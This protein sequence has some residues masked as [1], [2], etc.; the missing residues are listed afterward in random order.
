M[1]GVAR[2]LVVVTTVLYAARK[3]SKIISDH[4]KYKFLW[5]LIGSWWLQKREQFEHLTK[6]FTSRMVHFEIDHYQWSITSKMNHLAKRAYLEN[7]SFRKIGHFKSII[8]KMR[9][10]TKLKTSHFELVVC[11]PSFC[12][13]HHLEIDYFE[14]CAT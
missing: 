4:S 14:K 8:Y 6:C 11:N 10:F 1:N 3:N 9:H 12:K 13:M 5:L 2:F 7:R